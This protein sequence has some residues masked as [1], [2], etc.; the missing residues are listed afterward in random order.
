MPRQSNFE[1]MVEVLSNFTWWVCLILAV[2]S[3]YGFSYLASIEVITVG[4][5][6]DEMF[7]RMAFIWVVGASN[8]FNTTPQIN[9]YADVVGAL[10]PPT[11][12][13]G[14][15]GGFWYLQSRYDF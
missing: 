15:N 2:L 3:Y 7:G 11:S 10:Y 9:P 12:P 5:T 4:M 1:F 8:V 13:S 6:K 14:M